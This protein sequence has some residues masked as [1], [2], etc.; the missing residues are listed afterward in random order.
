MPIIMRGMFGLS[1]W[2]ISQ[3]APCACFSTIY[4][5]CTCRLWCC[6]LGKKVPAPPS[7]LAGSGGGRQKC[8]AQSCL[9]HSHERITIT[10]FMQLSTLRRSLSVRIGS[11]LTG[12]AAQPGARDPPR[13]WRRTLGM[14]LFSQLANHQHCWPCR[15]IKAEYYPHAMHGFERFAAHAG[16]CHPRHE[17]ACTPFGCVGTLWCGRTAAVVGNCGLREDSGR[18]FVQSVR[19]GHKLLPHSPYA[20]PSQTCLTKFCKASRLAV[21]MA[22]STSSAQP[23]NA[24]A[25]CQVSCPLPA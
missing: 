8:G 20:L 11:P 12:A 24:A 23:G 10:E 19:Q 1:C 15:C 16:S 22:S 3:H 14:G 25:A 2:L 6:Q 13:V 9:Q 4:G 18:A 5:D 7:T 21:T 17:G